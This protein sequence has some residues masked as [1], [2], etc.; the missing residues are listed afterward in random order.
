MPSVPSGTLNNQ[1]N[2]QQQQTQQQ[3]QQLPQQPYNGMGRPHQKLSFTNGFPS[4][5]GG[6]ASRID[7]D[8]TLIVGSDETIPKNRVGERVYSNNTA[9]HHQPDYNQF[10]QS[11]EDLV[12]H[13]EHQAGESSGDS[14]CGVGGAPMME[15]LVEEQSIDGDENENE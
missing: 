5:Y 6:F 11:P 2:S 15:P 10:Y 1:R 13:L 3:Q 7:S 4:R 9:S 14:N 8:S 12:H